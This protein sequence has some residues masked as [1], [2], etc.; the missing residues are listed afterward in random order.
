MLLFAV[1]TATVQVLSTAQERKW[2]MVSIVWQFNL[3]SIF[4][5]NVTAMEITTPQFYLN[6]QII[7]K[8]KKAKEV[9][10]NDF[11][12]TVVLFRS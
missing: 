9:I 3:K 11:I 4:F 5:K 7:L 10:E 12:P 8:H 1:A 2:A 6:D